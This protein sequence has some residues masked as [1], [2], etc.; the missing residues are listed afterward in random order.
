M[1]ESP[2]IVHYSKD[3]ALPLLLK[4]KANPNLKLGI[5]ATP[6]L[7]VTIQGDSDTVSLLLKA[8]AN[9]DLQA[10]DGTMTTLHC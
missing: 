4:A 9:P 2:C 3:K 7:A 5:G 6:L 1:S 10:S 8:N